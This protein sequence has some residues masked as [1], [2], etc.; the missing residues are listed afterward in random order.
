VVKRGGEAA[1][2]GPPRPPR[3]RGHGRGH[4]QGAPDRLHNLKNGSAEA[5][6]DVR[7]PGL[8]PV[9]KEAKPTVEGHLAAGTEGQGALPPRCSVA[10]TG[11]DETGLMPNAHESEVVP[12]RRGGTAGPR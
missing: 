5:W 2:P 11:R 10:P 1:H 9:R 8:R 12:T 6:A 7:Q 3:V 4:G